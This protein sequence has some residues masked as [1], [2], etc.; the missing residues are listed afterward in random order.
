[1]MI[2]WFKRSI[3]RQTTLSFL[4]TVILLIVTLSIS[5][6]WIYSKQLYQKSSISSF[7]Y[8]SLIQQL[9]H[10][11]SIEMAKHQSAQY[12]I[13]YVFETAKNHNTQWKTQ[14]D[15]ADISDLLT[16]LKTHPDGSYYASVNLTHYH[17]QQLN[18]QWLAY[19][20]PEMNVG[21]SSPYL[22]AMAVLILAIIILLYLMMHSLLQPLKPIEEGLSKIAQ[23]DFNT[24]IIVKGDNEISRFAAQINQLTTTISRLLESKRE[25]L[26]AISHELK[27]PLARITVLNHLSQHPQQGEIS[28]EIKEVS[29][30]IDELLESERLSLDHTCLHLEETDLCRFIQF[31]LEKDFLSYQANIHLDLPQDPI[32][33]TLDKT[34]IRVLINNLISNALKYAN[35]VSLALQQHVDAIH[36]CIADDGP[37]CSE[38]ELAKLAQPFYRPDSSRQK[39]TGGTG[40]GLYLCTKIMAAHGG[41]IHFTANSPTGLMV[42]IKF[43][44]APQ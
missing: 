31:C 6:A 24:R 13:D 35:N 44:L 4:F 10:P 22:L 14:P 37:G 43:N 27:T 1:M 12:A 7:A 9:G 8:S 25:I 20:S 26:L 41:H 32:L 29:Q 42:T 18:G 2:T 28:S 33:V 11:F 34:R 19:T 3:F 30:L 23:G 17:L 5:T 36:I 38:A 39:N 40:L 16:Q 21:F 15:L